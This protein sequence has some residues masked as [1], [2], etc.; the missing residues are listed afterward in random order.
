MSCLSNV[1]LTGMQF[2]VLQEAPE[3]RKW[4]GQVVWQVG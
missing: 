2:V 3:Q 4:S 1:E